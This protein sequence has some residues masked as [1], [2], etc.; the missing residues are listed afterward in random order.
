MKNNEKKKTSKLTD[1]VFI[2]EYFPGF[3]I[4]VKVKEISN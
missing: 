3:L 1:T 4:T 2:R